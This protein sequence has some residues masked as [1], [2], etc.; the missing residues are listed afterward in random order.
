MIKPDKEPVKKNELNGLIHQL[1]SLI[2][3]SS[4][5]LKTTLRFNDENINH[6]EIRKN[7]LKD[8]TFKGY[9][10]WILICSIVICSIGL[11]I[12][13]SAVVIGAMLISPLMGP[14]LGVGLSVGTNDIL[15]FKLSLQNFLIALGISL[16]TSTVFFL[17]SPLQDVQAEL[18]ARTQPTLLDALLAAFGGL[19]GIIAISRKDASN[20]IP[21]V[22][23]ATALMPPICT[24][25]YGLANGNFSFFLGALYL[26]LLNS[27]FISLATL[28]I[29]RYLRFPYISFID[30]LTEKKGK[31]HITLISLIIIIPSAFLFF[32]VTQESMFLRRANSFTQEFIEYPGSETINQKLNYSKE[33][34]SIEVFMIGKQIPDHVI[35]DWKDKLVKSDLQSTEL[36]VIQN[37]NN[38]EELAG[39]IGDRVKSGIIKEL[40]QNNVAELRSKNLKIQ[41][42]TN[43]IKNLQ[44]AKI[45]W[46][47]LQKEIFIQYPNLESLTYGSTIRLDSISLDTIPTL[48][49]IWKDENQSNQLKR[50]LQVRIGQD[51]IQVIDQNK[52]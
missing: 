29:I 24:A 17:I 14:I 10:V 7:I 18:L 42:L 30:K 37:Q 46:I 15:N 48:L 41:N 11:N 1:K 22:A 45:D 52:F 38:S 20:V 32:E 40:Y 47:Q 36:K 6:E 31:R 2:I 50:W 25:G 26:F 21:G 39:S 23:I 27:V 49:P 4:Q 43:E 34:S 28:I 33:G 13:S 8:I 12:N 9:N 5:L 35:E 16:L 51:K 3:N 19:A 44:G